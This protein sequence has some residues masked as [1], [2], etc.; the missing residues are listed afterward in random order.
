MHSVGTTSPLDSLSSPLLTR[1]Q[2]RP[3]SCGTAA[4]VVAALSSAGL[5]SLLALV[6]TQGQGYVSTDHTLA[7]LLLS[8]FPHA[9]MIAPRVAGRLSPYTVDATV[10]FG[11]NVPVVFL[12]GMGDS[13]SNPGMQSLCKSASDAYPGLH[14]VCASVC[15]GLAS[16]TTPLAEQVEEFASFVKRDERLR[17]GTRARAPHL[18]R[19]APATFASQLRRP[20]HL[21]GACA[22]PTL[23]RSPLRCVPQPSPDLAP[24]ASSTTMALCAGFHAVGLSQGGLVLRGY[25]ETRNDPPVRR[26]ISVCS[27]HAGIGSCPTNSLYKLVCPLWKLAPYT[28]RL[29]FADYWKDAS[30][31]CRH[32]PSR[33]RTL[34]RRCCYSCACLSARPLPLWPPPRRRSHSHLRADASWPRV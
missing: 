22:A 31:N 2:R 4:L 5:L 32:R 21:N 33:E 14:V 23:P 1:A 8:L 19:A 16:I 15:D 24:H 12:H 30:G 27:P 9:P 13:S 6:W 29:A 3:R 34:R 7:L 26:L 18:C 10:D 25:V 28:A 20:S 11:D 17:D